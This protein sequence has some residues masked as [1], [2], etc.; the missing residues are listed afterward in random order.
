M[1]HEELLA[2]IDELDGILVFPDGTFEGMGRG[3][4]ALLALR[5][6]V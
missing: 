2:K 6:V 3:D 1:T 4:K 5:A